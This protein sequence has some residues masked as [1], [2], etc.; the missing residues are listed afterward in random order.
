[1]IYTLKNKKI[2]H[3]HIPKT[4][5]GSITDF[6][7]RHA[8]VTRPQIPELGWNYGHA[9][10]NLI[11]KHINIADFDYIFTFIREPFPRALSAYHYRANKHGYRST[12]EEFIETIK[13]NY[14]K[15][16]GVFDEHAR[17]QVEFLDIP[18]LIIYKFLNFNSFFNDLNRITDSNFNHEELKWHNKQ[19]YDRVEYD[20]MKPA[21]E[22]F[23]VE[24]L[25]AYNDLL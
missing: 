13:N 15:T 1:M 16:P 12:F 23:Y 19:N 17:K 9:H 18:N 14:K 2:L 10:A 25:N 24:D 8:D 11:K 4:G 22:E 20:Y 7:T 5:G 6:L 3:V 21:V